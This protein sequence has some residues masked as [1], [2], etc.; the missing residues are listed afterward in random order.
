VSDSHQDVKQSVESG[1]YYRDAMKWY[2]TVYHAPISQRALLIIITSMAVAIIM[3]SMTGLFI[4]LPIKETKP[5]IVRVPDSLARVAQVVPLTNSPQ[6]D[7]NVAV[8]RWFMEDYVTSRES[9]DINRQQFYMNR[10]ARL[11][12]AEV[13]R[14]YAAVFRSSK[15]PT[16]RYESHTKRI[17]DISKIRI[18]DVD[19]VESATG[20][21]PEVISVEA[22]VEFQ[23]TEAAPTE[24]RKSMWGADISFRFT[25]IHVDQVSGEITGMKF[26]VTDY[27]SKQ[28]GLN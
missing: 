23:A 8:M 6:E 18:E 20:S 11:S 21:R 15:S 13:T 24:E 3:M 4:L 12:A 27:E 25:K 28:L 16:N 9:Y 2:S 7:P 5:M 10:V 14:A 26:V 1:E 17:I 22:Y 19:V